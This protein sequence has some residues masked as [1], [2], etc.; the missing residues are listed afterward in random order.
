[1]NSV[2][3]GHRYAGLPE[4]HKRISYVEEIAFSLISDT[5]S[6]NDFNEPV[7]EKTKNLGFKPGPTQTRLYKHRRWLEAGNFG[8][9]KKTQLLRS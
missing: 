9:R 6:G 4:K 2:Q 7:C 3:V 5:S 8:F 1:M